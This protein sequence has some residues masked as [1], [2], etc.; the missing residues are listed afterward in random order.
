M[1]KPTPKPYHP[2]LLWPKDNW[3]ELDD[4][5]RDEV[6]ILREEGIETTE[7]CQGGQGHAYPEPTV[8]FRGGHGDEYRAVAAAVM[9]G[10]K[11][12][13]LRKVWT[14]SQGGLEGPEWEMTFIHRPGQVD[15]GS[16]PGGTGVER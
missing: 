13:Q 8:R 3:P 7:S 11:V 14:F 12:W 10:L 5:I 15:V 6:R 9:R 2:V 1:S 4:G 16:C